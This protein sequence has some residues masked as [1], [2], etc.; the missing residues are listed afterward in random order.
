ML[1]STEP[2]RPALLRPFRSAGLVL[3]LALGLLALGCTGAGRPVRTAAVGGAAISRETLRQLRWLEGRWIADDDAVMP[4]YTAYLFDSDTSL[5]FLTYDS[6]TFTTPLE[7]VSVVLAGGRLRARAGEREWVAA[8]ADSASVTL[9][10]VG[11]EAFEEV[12]VTR[13]SRDVL[14]LRIRWRY[15]SGRAATHATRARRVVP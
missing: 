12:T 8:A 7:S 1:G 14:R 4:A 15:E 13:V 5:S 2:S 9:V 11:R 10:A 6:R 3:L